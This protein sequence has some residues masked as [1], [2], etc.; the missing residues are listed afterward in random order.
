M[1]RLLA[2]FPRDCYQDERARSISPP[3]S[4]MARNIFRT[5]GLFF[6]NEDG[7]VRGAEENG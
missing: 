2:E 3:Y 4:L 1:V 6:I 5:S 7:G